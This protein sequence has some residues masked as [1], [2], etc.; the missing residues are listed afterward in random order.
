M[1]AKE[2]YEKLGYKVLMNNKSTL[3]YLNLLILQ[4]LVK[5][6]GVLKKEKS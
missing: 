4:H 1:S 2:M 6:L 5:R 3:D